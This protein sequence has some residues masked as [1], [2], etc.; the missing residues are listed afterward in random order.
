[1]LELICF[2][3]GAAVMIL[4]IAGARVFAPYFGTSFIIWTSL[5]GIVMTFLSLGYWA[6]GK[7]GDIKK[8]SFLLSLIIFI[9]GFFILLTALT[10]FKYLDFLS[11]SSFLNI[12]FQCIFGAI[13]LFGIPSMFLGMVSPYIISLAIKED[14][15]NNI[16]SK[17]GR[18]Y[19]LSTIGSIFGTF[20]CGFYLITHF[21]I[22][23]IF[24]FLE[25]QVILC[26]ILALI[27]YL[28]K[29]SFDVKTLF[30]ASFQLILITAGLYFMNFFLNKPVKIMKNQ[31]DFKES[32]YQFIGVTEFE[33]NGVMLK[34]LTTKKGQ[35]GVSVL[36]HNDIEQT[37]DYISYFNA[38]RIYKKDQNCILFLGGGGYVMPSNLLIKANREKEP[39]F[40]DVVEIDSAMT[41]TAKKHFFLKPDSRINIHHIDA[42]LYLN[43]LIKDKTAEKYDAVYYDL[44]NTDRIIPYETI[45]LEALQKI[46]YILK[47]D[48][49]F[50]LNLISALEGNNNRLFRIVYTTIK[51]VYPHIT[52]IKTRRD[53]TEIQNVII[54]A[55]KTPPMKHYPAYLDDIMKKAYKGKIKETVEIF[56]DDYAPV[57]KYL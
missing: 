27:Y 12:Y 22:M 16:S 20:V 46:H 31:I 26:S 24:L 30:L 13:F 37:I 25:I 51:K 47:K 28:K 10:Q 40:M 19:A 33:D 5:I 15:D 42:R 36:F 6:G 32:Q 21:G 4:E 9:S 41:E 8:S 39:I 2:I 23:R 48:G 52:I 57:E 34:V 17:I 44:P 29:N 18:F 55:G 49:V 3:C 1:M 54:I 35:G 53:N 11:D 56:T 45:T 7:L 43:K 38:S 14:S 50:A